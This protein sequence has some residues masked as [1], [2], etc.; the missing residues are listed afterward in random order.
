[1]YIHKEQ[2]QKGNFKASDAVVHS[3]KIYTGLHTFQ[4]AVYLPAVHNSKQGLWA[5]LDSEII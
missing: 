4:N 2:K 1:M 5:F 3:Y